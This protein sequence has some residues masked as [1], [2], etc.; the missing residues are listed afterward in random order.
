MHPARGEPRL[1]GANS[2]PWPTADA[3]CSSSM[4]RGRSG[5]SISRIPSAIAPEVTIA[6]SS[7]GVV[8]IGNLSADPVEHVT[9][10]D[11]G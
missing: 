2:V 3:A 1:V 8:Q 10:H 6:T 9:A 11:A 4:V 7:P 5:I